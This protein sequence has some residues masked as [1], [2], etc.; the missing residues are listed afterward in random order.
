[1]PIVNVSNQELTKSLYYEGPKGSE[2]KVKVFIDK[3][4]P[5]KNKMGVPKIKTGEPMDFRITLTDDV[6]QSSIWI[7]GL[8][9]AFWKTY[10]E[11]KNKGGFG[12]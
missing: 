4:F 10:P 8:N 9:E 12:Y 6:P 7:Q 3:Q 5:G 2:F 11:L 1:M